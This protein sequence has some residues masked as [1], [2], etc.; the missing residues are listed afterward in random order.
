MR[1]GYFRERTVKVLTKNIQ[2]YISSSLGGFYFGRPPASLSRMLEVVLGQAIEMGNTARALLTVIDVPVDGQQSAL[3]E[4]YLSP[5]GGWLVGWRS[6]G[7]SKLRTARSQLYQ[8]QL[9]QVNSKYSL[10]SP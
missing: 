8:S 3:P 9:L 5:M 1:P 6:V 4:R 10:E 7:I 2:F